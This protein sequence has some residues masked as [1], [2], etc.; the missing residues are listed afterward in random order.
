MIKLGMRSVSDTVKAQGV[1]SAYNELVG[2]LKKYGKDD[3]SLCLNRDLRKCDVVHYHTIDPVSLAKMLTARKITVASV[4]FMPETVKNSL[5]LPQPVSCLLNH[6]M[7]WFYKSAD[8]LHIVNPSAV[9]PLLACGVPRKRIRVIPNVVSTDGFFKRNAQER[10]KIRSRCEFSQKD[11]I[12]IGCGQLQNRKGIKTFAQVARLMPD[13]RFVWVGGF[14]FGAMSDGYAE[15]KRLTEAPPPNLRFTGIV[16]RDEVSALMGAADVFF[17]PSFHEQ[18]SMAILEAAS[19]GLPLVLRDLSD[20]HINYGANCLYAK[21]ASDFAGKIHALHSDPKL[22]M[23]M[24]ERAEKLTQFYS[25]QR[26][27]TL[28]KKFY[29]ECAKY[30]E[31]LR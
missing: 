18:F 24:T 29:G 13:I 12:V 30:S 17:L 28:W 6:Y 1:G 3:F 7:L 14:S 10:Q 4:H 9:E 21:N 15:L 27:Y 20:Y 8:F 19:C 25:E 26:I 22:W 23:E 2:L 31:M 16:E 11:F 5:K